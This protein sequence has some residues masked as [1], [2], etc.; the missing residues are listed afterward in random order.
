[1]LYLALHLI[2]LFKKKQGIGKFV[3]WTCILNGGTM[4]YECIAI[5]CPV[6]SSEPEN[7]YD[8]CIKIAVHCYI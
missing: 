3:Q 7:L 2:G 8:D 5:L 1:M 4:I 6:L